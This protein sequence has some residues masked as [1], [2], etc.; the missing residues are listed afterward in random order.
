MQQAEPPAQE[1]L[2]QLL[3]QEQKDLPS[4]SDA[5][6]STHR[7]RL[8]TMDVISS[9]VSS[10]RTQLGTMD[11]ISSDRSAS[12][13]QPPVSSG[14]GGDVT[15]DVAAEKRRSLKRALSQEGAGDDIWHR[16][17]AQCSEKERP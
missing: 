1:L 8:G 16:N 11:V 17:V 9:E 15:A 7:T 4:A 12:S 3:P 14:S 6:V 10:P 5:E 13:S 2:E